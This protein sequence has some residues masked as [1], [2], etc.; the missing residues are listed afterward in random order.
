[1]SLRSFIEKLEND[2]KLK[3]VSKE[4]STD[5]EIANVMS[6]LGD[7][8]VLFEKIKESDMRLVGNVCATRELVSKAF[9]VDK[10]ELL[11]TI[12]NAAEN[13]KTPEIVTDAPCQEVV[14][15]KPDLNKIPLLKHLEKDGER[16]IT[17]GVCVIEDNE[18]GRNS[19]YHRMMC[20]SPTDMVGRI[21]QHRGTDIA[22]Q[23]VKELEMAICLGNSIPVLIAA[24]TSLAKDQDELAMAN[25]IEDTPLVKCKTID[26]HVPKDTE[27][28]IEGVLTKDETDEG[29]FLDLTET[30]DG[31]RKQPTFRVKCITHRKNPIYHALLP[32]K[33]EHK[34]LMGMPKEP[35]MFNEVSKVV[36]CKDVL[37]TPG[38]CN[39]LHGVVS[40]TKKTEQ[41][42]RK[43][44]EAMFKGHKSL[45]H[46]VVFDSDVNI[47]DPAEMEWAIATRVQGSKDIIIFKDQFGSSLDPSALAEPG[48]KTI[49]DKVGVDATIPLDKDK[50]EFKKVHYPTVNLKDYGLGE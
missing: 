23:K 43:A 2:G 16:Y 26:V 46:C 7:T 50:K 20:V 1:M 9:D 33:L 45:K 5:L 44:I 10:S 38:G 11:K 32:G 3:K 14:L 27:I 21:I 25:A 42:G 29:P 15:D 30:Y 36:E 6:T 47:H 22:L 49:T 13:L 4:V 41:D 17:S 18:L 35:T 8:P 24:S 28:V 31:V 39:W 40:I 12:A 19:C 48:K 37:I 34:I